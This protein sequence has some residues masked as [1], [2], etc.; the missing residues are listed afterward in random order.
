M[1]SIFAS[2]LRGTGSN[3]NAKPAILK[4]CLCVG[5]QNVI[6][7]YGAVEVQIHTYINNVTEMKWV[8]SKQLLLRFT[9]MRRHPVSNSLDWP[10]SQSEDSGGEPE[11]PCTCRE[12]NS[13]RPASSQFLYWIT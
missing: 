1:V 7:M 3:F 8:V 12:S 13:G 9:S 2:G 10:H 4:L 6:E 11:N 5:K